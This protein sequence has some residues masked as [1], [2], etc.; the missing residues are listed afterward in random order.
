MIGALL[1]TVA[2]AR[3]TPAKWAQT[4]SKV[5]VTFPMRPG[6]H[7][8]AAQIIYQGDALHF[9]M[10]CKES[11]AMIIDL[12]YSVKEEEP[13][14][15]VQKRGEAVVT[16]TKMTQKWW[17]HLQKDPDDHANLITRDMSHYG[18]GAPDDW[19][20]Y[21]KD[22]EE[23]KAEEEEEEEEEA[24]GKKKFYTGPNGK[25]A[26]AKEEEERERQLAEEVNHAFQLA[27]SSDPKKRKAAAAHAKT[28]IRLVPHAPIA[29]FAL[30]HVYAGRHERAHKLS[31]KRRSQATDALTTALA[32]SATP[33][34]ARRRLKARV[35]ASAYHSLAILTAT[36]PKADDA[37][38]RTVL[39]HLGHAVGLSP[40]D[41][42][43]YE[44]YSRARETIRKHGLA[45]FASSLR[46]PA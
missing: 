5:I 13:A 28:A 17:K 24:G 23:V 4:Q 34:D 7:S 30:G 2:A 14:R 44:S 45:H 41:S 16:L 36:Q 26:I 38:K 42:S 27:Q 15:L 22:A 9:S 46:S 18:E 6:C 21:A 39:E 10:T 20:S 11:I 43:E 25:I 1:V 29:Y 19:A 35:T 31:K 12:A 3:P 33:Q 37:D 40:T 32:M 8:E